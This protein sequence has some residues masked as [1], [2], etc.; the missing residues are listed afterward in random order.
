MN[1]IINYIL[2]F[3]FEYYW[4]GLDSPYGKLMAKAIYT[5][6]DTG[7]VIDIWEDGSFEIYNQFGNEP[8]LTIS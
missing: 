2:D 6:P 1:T 3:G 7:D 4:S 8:L 5:N